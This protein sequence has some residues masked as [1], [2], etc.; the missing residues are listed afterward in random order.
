MPRQLHECKLSEPVSELLRSWGYEVYTEI[1]YFSS[2][3][4][5]VAMKDG[6]TPE[7]IA[8][9]LKVSL[10][11]KVIRQA[12]MSTM[13]M[14]KAFCAIATNPQKKSLEACAKFGL[15]VIRVKDGKAKLIQEFH[16]VH[17]NEPWQPKLD[18]MIKF[19]RAIEPGGV[20]GNPT[21]PGMGPAQECYERVLEYR[22]KHPKAKWKEIFEHVHNHYSTHLSMAGAMRIAGPKVELRMAKEKHRSRSA[23]D[24]PGLGAESPR[25]LRILTSPLLLQTMGSVERAD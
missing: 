16:R 6:E 2:C 12:Y 17:N 19:L 9:E 21:L 1:P 8:V 22:A 10:T 5:M 4:D 14:H 3:I 7:L 11:K 24:A 20:A 15:G 13:T 18:L 25:R 23:T